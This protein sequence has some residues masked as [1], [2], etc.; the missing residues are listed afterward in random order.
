MNLHDLRPVEGVNESGIRKS[1]RSG[2]N[3]LRKELNF[4]C[5]GVRK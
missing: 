1:I 2:L 3:M 4:F 5:N